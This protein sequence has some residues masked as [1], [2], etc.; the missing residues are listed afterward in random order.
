[1]ESPGNVKS[2]IPTL[3]LITYLPL[4]LCQLEKPVNYFYALKT[5]KQKQYW[6]WLSL[7]LQ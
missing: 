1:M 2:L 5:K 4:Y 3:E 6:I 7:D